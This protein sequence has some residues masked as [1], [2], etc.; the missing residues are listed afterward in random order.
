M[1]ACSKRPSWLAVAG[2]IALLLV[3][4]HAT[5]AQFGS[6]PKPA[7]LV[8]IEVAPTRVEAGGTAKASVTLHVLQG[9]HINANPAANENSIPTLV[10][11]TGTSG[12]SAEETVYPTPHV[13]KLPIDDQP[14]FVWDGEATLRVPLRA[15]A[16]ASGRH[17]LKGAL[18]FQACND[19]VCLPPATLAFDV[20]VEI[21]SMESGGAA[22]AGAGESGV[23]GAG[24]AA[25]EAA[26]PKDSGVAGSSRDSSVSSGAGFATT[27]PANPAP[28]VVRSP[29]A[30]VL[31]RGGWAAF[32]ALF[33]I[34]LALNLTPC[35]YPLIGVTVS[36]FGA[37]RSAPPLKVF[38]S[39][40]IYVLGMATMYSALG[41]AASFSGGLFGGWLSNPIVAV[42]IGLLLI[43]LSLSMF[44]L[45][46]LNV[47]SALLTRLG[48]T[49]ASSALGIFASGLVVGVFAAPCVGPPVVALL[50]VVG[51]KGDPWF[52]FISFFTLAMGLGAPYLVLGTFSNLIQSLPRSGEWMIWV[53]K[54]FGLI[55]FAVGLNYMVLALAPSLASWVL[56][57]ALVLGGV[58]L[59]LVDRTASQRA[60]FR[61]FKRGAGVAAAA[62]GIALVALAPSRGLALQPL[63]AGDLKTLAAGGPL[64]IDFSAD[65]CQPCHEL[66]RV[67][68]TDPRVIDAARGLRAFQVDLTR[69]DSPE[70]DRWRRTWGIRGVPT[71]VFVGPDGSEIRET[72][73]EGFVPPRTFLDRIAI[74]KA[75]LA[76]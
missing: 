23:A 38:L 44:G 50:A 20:P 48:G 64:L 39:A 3:F 56:P 66:E 70:A 75:A 22:A 11:V 5:H 30:D 9:W 4:A 58:W 1:S 59:G 61:V 31:D 65:W 36:I 28:A 18:R 73:T 54:V 63:P 16:A 47:P 55:L 53:K 74:A 15:A 19:R 17:S 29:L 42:G 2:G 6:I 60:G 10:T 40:L 35:V 21:V 45:Y 37:R 69:Y 14:L 68:F 62:A 24:S 76:R 52:G 43:G 27:P 72:R 46:E 67:T 71:V 51:Q 32:L 12:V 7:D 33:L 34:G 57:A 41:L 13:V 26:A 25:S 8:R 49:G